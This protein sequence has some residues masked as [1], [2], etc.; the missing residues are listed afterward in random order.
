MLRW[1]ALYVLARIWST[2]QESVK[3]Y[4]NHSV[5]GE[6]AKLDADSYRPLRAI[7]TEQDG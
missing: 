4:G 3:L 1:A 5:D 6:L 2:H 7:T